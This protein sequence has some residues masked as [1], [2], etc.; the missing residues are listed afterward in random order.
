MTSAQELGLSLQRFGWPDYLVFGVMLLM[1][2]L[3]GVYFGFYDKA[4]NATAS[5]YLMGGRNMK[6]FPV[7]MSLIAR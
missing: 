4:N 7:A 6:T 3:I 2:A 5:E 1:C